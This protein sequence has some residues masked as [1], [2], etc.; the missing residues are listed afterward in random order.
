MLGK[1]QWLQLQSRPD[2]SHEVN[3]AAQRSSAP[4]VAGARTLNAIALKARR[5]SETILRYT[6]CVTDVATAQLV[7]CGDASFAN[8][9]GSKS[10][11]GVTVF[12]THDPRRFWKG[13][14]QLGHLVYWTSTAI[15][16]VVR[17]TLAADVHSVSE[18]VEEAQWLRSVLAEMWPSVSCSLPREDSG[19]G[20]PA[21]IDCDT[22]RLLQPLPSSQIGQLNR[23]GQAAPDGDSDVEA[24]LL[25][26]TRSN[27]TVTMLA[28]ALAKPLVHCPSLLAAMNAR[29]YVL[30][31]SE[32]ST[33]GRTN[34]PAAPTLKM[35]IGSQ[36]IRSVAS[37]SGRSGPSF[38]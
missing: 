32:S 25:W 21:P 38:C 31:T 2:L 24:S 36:M 22:L 37:Q 19:N 1:T 18:A 14:F 9:E 30:V 13:E 8:V 23:K 35:A 26:S 29:H 27:T 17:S 3:R 16:R 20:F 11:C 34:L 4:T 15:K 12:L 5:S 10:Q 7:T 28:D 6:R 33:G